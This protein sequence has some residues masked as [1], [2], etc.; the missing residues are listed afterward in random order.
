MT[1]FPQDLKAAFIKHLTARGLELDDEQITHVTIKYQGDVIFTAT[2]LLKDGQLRMDIFDRFPD[3][4]SG[5]LMYGKYMGG[6]E[7][8]LRWDDLKALLP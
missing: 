2:L 6:A 7:Y 4:S 1:N 8:S 3:I 5:G